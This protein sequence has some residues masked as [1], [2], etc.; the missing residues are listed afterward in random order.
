M[1]SVVIRSTCAA[2]PFADV[3]RYG[4]GSSCSAWLP[5][6]LRTATTAVRT[7]VWGSF[8]ATSK[9]VRTQRETG[10]H[11]TLSLVC[12]CNL[13]FAQASETC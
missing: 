13:V 11:R 2:P 3:G 5:K 8:V 6:G 10:R 1:V 7:H 12:L 9:C 4:S